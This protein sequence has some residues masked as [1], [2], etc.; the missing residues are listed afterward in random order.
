MAKGKQP[1]ALAAYQAG[2]RSGSHH[3]TPQTIVVRQAAAPTSRK[4]KGKGGHRRG[5]ASSQKTLMGMA[6][7]GFALGFVDKSGTSIPTIPM[8]GRAGTIALAAHF[9][10]KGRPG[11]LTDIRNAAAAVAAYEM[12]STGK[13]AGEGV[14]GGL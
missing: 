11:L 5:H 12:G 3:G 8:L 2:L 13:I 6:M 14:E 1:A 7:G 10:G 9:I 4:G